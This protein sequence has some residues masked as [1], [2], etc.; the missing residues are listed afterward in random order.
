LKGAKLE[1]M[2][3]SARRKYPPDVSKGKDR[4]EESHDTLKI[5]SLKFKEIY[6]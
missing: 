6:K 2:G 1:T 4:K 5:Q 3:E